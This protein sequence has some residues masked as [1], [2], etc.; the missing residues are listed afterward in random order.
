MLQ[1]G[2]RYG[3]IITMCDRHDEHIQMIFSTTNDM[4]D[5]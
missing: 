1:H 4:N 5:I 2:K 3:D